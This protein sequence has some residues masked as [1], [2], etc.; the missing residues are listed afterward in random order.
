MGKHHIAWLQDDLKKSGAQKLTWRQHT[1]AITSHS[2]G[3]IIRDSE[4]NKRLPVTRL[5]WFAWAAFH[6][7][8][9]LGA[10]P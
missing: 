5:Y 2:D 10:L 8:T 9:E 3:I 1:L 6:P 7:D 4:T